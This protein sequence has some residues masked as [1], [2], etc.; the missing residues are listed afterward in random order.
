MPDR[1]SVRPVVVLGLSLS[2]AAGCTGTHD[3]RTSNPPAPEPE[4][5][6]NPPAPEPEPA[7]VPAP[8]P[9]TIPEVAP[10]PAPAPAPTGG[11]PTWDQVPSGHPPGATNPPRPVLVVTTDTHRC[12]KR[13]V[14]PMVPPDRI[15]REVTDA[16]CADGACGTE[17]VCPEDKATP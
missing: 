3:Q 16:E 15:Q 17:I 1:P 8:T 9:D 10:A 7:P 12:F 6:H 5:S 11:L 14:S 4:I 2:L 13:W